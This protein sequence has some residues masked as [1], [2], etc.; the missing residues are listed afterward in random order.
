M[1]NTSEQ[2]TR[3]VT[4]RIEGRVQGVYYR[5]WTEENARLLG[6]DGWV[7]NAR[8]GSVEAAFSGRAEKVADMLRL[9]ERG[10]AHARVTKVIVTGEGGSVPDGFRVLGTD[11]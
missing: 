4:V 11:W 3:T 7:R 9:C 8:D 5:A 6:L 10:P 2:N 1:E